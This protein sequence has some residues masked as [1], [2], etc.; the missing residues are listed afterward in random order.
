MPP[1]SWAWSW[2]FTAPMAR[3]CRRS[4]ST[5]VSSVLMSGGCLPLRRAWARRSATG[6]GSRTGS[7]FSR[8]VNTGAAR[9]ARVARSTSPRQPSSRSTRSWSCSGTIGSTVQP[10]A[11]LA[12]ALAQRAVG[13]P[14]HRPAGHER[15]GHHVAEGLGV[16]RGQ[17]HDLDPGAVEQLGQHLVVVRAVHVQVLG[18]ASVPQLAEV[19]DLD[20]GAGA[21]GRPAS[22]TIVEA[23]LRPAQADEARAAAARRRRGRGRAPA[24]ARSRSMIAPCGMSSMRSV[25][26]VVHAEH[27]V[28]R[29]LAREHPVVDRRRGARRPSPGT[30]SSW[31]DGHA[32]GLGEAAGADRRGRRACRTADWFLY[33][34]QWWGQAR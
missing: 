4:R 16:G 13:R 17:Q 18:A 34:S 31:L 2:R 5:S 23:L 28:G 14:D 3:T 7:A 33:S 21:T 11:E 32:A 9:A 26:D 15:L 10:G 29:A 6:T 22:S 25:G 27:V 20:A 19:V 8:S 12:D 30:S 1:S 24:A